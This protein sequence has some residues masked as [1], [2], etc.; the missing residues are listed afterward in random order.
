MDQRKKT[1][2]ELEN[3]KQESLR[4]LDLIRE[5][6]GARLLE[7]IGDADFPSEDLA[8]YRRLW[9]ETLDS[10]GRIK[11]IEEDSLR[12]QAL[13]EELESKEGQQTAQRRELADLT[14]DLGKEILGD[15][16]N[17][18]SPVFF[19]QQADLLA[20]RLEALEARL[21]EMETREGGNL[22]SWIGKSAQA[23]ITRSSLAK[24][25]NKLHRLYETV[26]E[27][28]SRS[29]G[30]GV[31]A[32][33][34]GLLR[35]IQKLKKQSQALEEDMAELRE[36][37]RELAARTGG[38]SGPL[39]NIRDLEKHLGRIKEEFAVLYRHFGGEAAAGAK[40]QFASLLDEGDQQTLEK[41]ALIQKT[42]AGYEDE[43][44]KLK[45]SLG[46][47]EAKREIEKLEKA[48]A[49]QQDRIAAAETAIAAYTQKIAEARARIGEFSKRLG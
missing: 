13:D 23:L 17:T 6:L 19:R 24:A 10:R 35:N 2:A 7:R 8:E 42:V 3:K 25:R 36:K 18:E 37:R 28:F 1:I 30:A 26:G 4:S 45:A 12:I 21:A 33:Q 47:D 31:P 5:D 34:S 38:R 32:A 27:Q 20:S 39:K 43:I 41:I 40:K 11:T 22:F 46:I 49:E 48:T 44:E 16:Q 9:K 14:L 29:G 15:P